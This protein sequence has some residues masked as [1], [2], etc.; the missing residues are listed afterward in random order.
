MS[1]D[2]MVKCEYRIDRRSNLQQLL[3][4]TKKLKVLARR[5]GLKGT[6]TWTEVNETIR[7]LKEKL[8]ALR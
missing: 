8:K 3:R 7:M 2:A 1:E 5:A 4:D 6:Q